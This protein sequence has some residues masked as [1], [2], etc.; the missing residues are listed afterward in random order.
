LQKLLWLLKINEDVKTRRPGKFFFMSLRPKQILTES[1]VQAGLRRGIREGLASEAMSTLTGGAFLVALA[2]LM[3]ANNFQIGLLAALPT[4]TNI[5]QL[6]SIWLVRRFNNRRM[7][8]VCCSLLARLPLLVIGCLTLV[9]PSMASIRLLIFFLVFYYF[10]GSISGP[11][12]N[13]WMKDLIPEKSLG[14]YFSRRSSYMQMLNVILSIL[15]ALLLDDVKRNY[16][17]FLLTTYGMMFALAGV[18][19][20]TGAFVLSGIPEPA[21]EMSRENIFKLFRQPLKNINFRSLLVFNSAWVFAI[22]IAIP[23][24]TVFMLTTLKLSLSYIIGLGI[25]SQ[26]CSILTIRIWGTFADR[27]SNKTIIAIGAPLYIGCIIAWCYVGIFSQAYAN[28][29]LLAFIHIFMG[30]ATSGINLSLTNIGLKLAP[31][32][33]AIVYLSVKNVVTALFSS[34]APLIG[35]YLADYFTERQLSV[36]L[37]WTGP[38]V[39]KI[40]HLVALHQWNFLFIIGALLA[41]FSLELLG[42]VKES[43]EVEKDIVVRI[44]RSSIRSNLKE[45]FLIGNLIT[46]HDY[47]W[48][49]IRRSGDIFRKRINAE[50]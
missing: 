46:F 1:E 42:R 36:L 18:I 9:L 26:L 13:S 6:L 32:E 37:Q 14:S 48:S 5:F 7:V 43:G 31:R 25:L 29:A 15:L 16:P 35:G 49:K 40:F 4:V 45:H 8:S 11:S 39:N 47:F 19:G 21:P 22:N 38:R 10:F 3:G 2:L 17:Q 24:F 28:L 20:I 27:Y 44:M 12:W 50:K 41:L 34:V 33:D 23:F 30:I